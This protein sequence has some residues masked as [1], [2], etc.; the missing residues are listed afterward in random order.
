MGA[1]SKGILGPFSGTVGTVIG[2]SWKGISYMRSQPVAKKNRVP[3][4]KQLDQQARFALVVGF[5]RTMTQLVAIGFKTPLQMSGFN[6]AVSF[7]LKNAVTGTY[8]S[9]SIE[10]GS[11]LVSRGDLPNAT[12]PGAV[13]TTTSLITWNWTDNSGTGNAVATDKSILAVFCPDLNTT[14]YNTAG[15]ARSTGTASLDV[16]LFTGHVIETYI[17][18]IAESGKEVASSLYT[19]DITLV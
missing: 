8:P 19:G 6:N 16:S 3:S 18:F 11:V 1:I 15:A 5:L 4:P 13:A 17:G 12:S 14:L 9:Y 2:G 10:Y 7:T